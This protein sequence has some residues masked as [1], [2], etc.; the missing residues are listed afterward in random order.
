MDN[1]EIFAAV[2]DELG[3]SFDAAERFLASETGCFADIDGERIWM[4][5]QLIA[6]ILNAIV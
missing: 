3:I 2:A 6:R 1:E 4:S 5:G